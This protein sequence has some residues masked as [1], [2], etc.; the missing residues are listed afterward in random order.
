MRTQ[1]TKGSSPLTRGKPGRRTLPWRSWGLIPAHAG[2]TSPARCGRASRTAH[3]R[4]RGE[5]ISGTLWPGLQNG[6]SPLTR[7]KRDRLTDRTTDEGLIPAHAGKTY[8]K[9]RASRDGRAHPR[10]RGENVASS[11]ASSFMVGSSPLTRGKPRSAH[12]AAGRD[13]LIPAHAGKTDAYIRVG[14]ALTGSSPL[15]R[16][17]PRLL[18]QVCLGR[19]LIPAHAGKTHLPGRAAY[20]A[21]A[22]P[23]SRGENV[24]PVHA[25]GPPAGSSP[26]TRGKPH[27]SSST[28]PPRRLIPA[29]AGKT[30]VPIRR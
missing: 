23:R 30:F 22:H 7:G 21:G 29:H 2:K 6:S 3:P 14:N 8:H 17:K 4:S 19:G 1:I 20:Q 25:E 16:G 18:P 24:L 13:G 5:N 15:T 28:P 9:V 27:G 26:L 11:S 10:S 12:K